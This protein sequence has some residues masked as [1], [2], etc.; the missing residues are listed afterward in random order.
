MAL[1]ERNYFTILIP[2][3]LD[4]LINIMTFYAVT[5][6]KITSQLNSDIS[7]QE[8]SRN[9]S[10]AKPYITISKLQASLPIGIP[11]FTKC[12]ANRNKENYVNT[13]HK[14]VLE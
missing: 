14:R 4:I 5:E 12:S 1:T 8:N 7:K 10:M 13:N 9:S 3:T 11:N 2:V 6:M